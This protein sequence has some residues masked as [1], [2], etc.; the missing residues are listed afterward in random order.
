MVDPY[1]SERTKRGSYRVNP[2]KVHV[3]EYMA[4]TGR[5]SLTCTQASR[6]AYTRRATAQS[7]ARLRGT[8]QAP[9]SLVARPSLLTPGPAPPLRRPPAPSPPRHSPSRPPP[10]ESPLP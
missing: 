9:P 3:N 5:L 8:F 7:P 6:P 2:V 1:R 10:R 4:E